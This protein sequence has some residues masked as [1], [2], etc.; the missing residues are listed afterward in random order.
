MSQDGLTLTL[1][2]ALEYQHLG[3]T[4]TL[5]SGH[6]LQARAP[7]GL[8]SRNVRVKGSND[9]DWNVKIEACEEGFNPGK[10]TL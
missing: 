7:V 8:L 6:T 9:P 4:L 5:E 3:E 2:L 1:E 10:L